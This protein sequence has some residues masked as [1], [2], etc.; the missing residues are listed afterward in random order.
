MIIG[1]DLDG[2]TGDY[3]GTLLRAMAKQA[4]LT[5]PA[6]ID[7]YLATKGEPSDYEMTS[8]FPTRE[9]FVTTHTAAVDDGL[10]LNIPV[11]PGA[12]EKLWAL[13][14][15]GHDIHIVTSRFVG[16][17]RNNRVV[18]HTAEWLDKNDIPYRSI[19]FV[20]DKFLLKCDVFVDD[21]PTNIEKL[22]EAGFEV[23]IYDAPYN[24]DIPGR[25]AHNWNEVYA[26]IKEIEALRSYL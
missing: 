15:E 18:H 14:D 19:H 3:A 22:R 21:A 12:S 13:S 9:A 10:Y 20:K 5:T 25:R 23:I 6:D 8:W 24:R 17:R 2:T 11:F 1:L 26:H 4:G 16:H 7:A